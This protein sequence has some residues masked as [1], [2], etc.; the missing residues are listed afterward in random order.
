[1]LL[2]FSDGDDTTSHTSAS[3]VID[4]VRSTNVT[5]YPV[6]FPAERRSSSSDIRA[7][8]FLGELARSSGGQVFRPMASRELAEIYTRILDELGGQYV[9]GFV[10]DNRERDGKYRH[11]KVEVPGRDLKV[12]HR[13]GYMAPLPASPDS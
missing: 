5:I 8:A 3:E 2:I 12:R 11:L 7:R 10:S 1:V 9:L 13:S 4:L 6:A